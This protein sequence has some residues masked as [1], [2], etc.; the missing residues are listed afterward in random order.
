MWTA[1]HA[2]YLSVV[3]AQNF[4]C[5]LQSGVGGRE[6]ED[7]ERYGGVMHLRFKYW[8]LARLDAC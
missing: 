3:H 7:K 4:V 2:D 5:F 1:S 6:R 8:H